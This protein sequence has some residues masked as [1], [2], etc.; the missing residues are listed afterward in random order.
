MPDVLW[1]AKIALGILGYLLLP[2]VL[3]AN[4]LDSSRSKNIGLSLTYGFLLQLLNIF[5]AWIFF[6]FLGS[7][8]FFF[9]ITFFTFVLIVIFLLVLSTRFTKISF[10]FNVESLKRMDFCLLFA[11]GL[12]LV[13]AYHFQQFAVE[14]HSD[15]ASYVDLARNVVENGVFKSSMIAPTYDWSNVVYSTGGHPHMFGY[16]A[17]ALFFLFGN[18][19][20][21]SAKI[22]LIF[23]GLLIINLTYLLTKEL[24]DINTARLASVMTSVSAIFLTH[25]G[26][27]GGPEIISA[28]FV[29]M[30]MYLI[31]AYNGSNKNAI[32]LVA[33]LSSFIAWYAVEF[34]FFV[35][36]ALFSL[37]VVF[38]ARQREED[39][40]INLFFTISLLV[41]F[42]IDVRMSSYFSFEKIGIPIPFISVIM[43]PLVYFLSIRKNSKTSQLSIVMISALIVLEF[44][45]LSFILSTPESKIFHANLLRVGIARANVERDLG[46]ISRMF[47]I[48]NIIHYWNMY[49]NG[50][51]KYLGQV[52]ILLAI[53][54]LGRLEKLKETI[55]LMLFPLFH[56]LLWIFF[57]T[58]DGF[59]PRFIVLCSIFYGILVASS[60]KTI[61]KNATNLMRNNKIVQLF[62]ARKKLR[63]D[64]KKLAGLSIAIMLIASYV[65]LAFETYNEGKKVMEFW[66][67]RQ[68]Y[69]W[70]DAIVWIKNNTYQTDAIASIY[71]DYFGW[72]TN[73]P[74][75]F[76]WLVS[77]KNESTLINLIRTLKV[78]YLVVDETFSRHFLDLKGLYDSPGPFLGS[79]IVFRSQ[80]EVGKKVVIYNVTN[81]AYGNLVTYEFEADWETLKHWAPLTFYSTGNISV[82]QDAVRFDLRV[83]GTQ[84]PSAAATFTFSSLANISQY[85]YMEFWIKVPKCQY[86][87]LVIYSHSE[88][89]SQNYFS[90]VVQNITVD[91][92][93]KNVIDLNS[94]KSIYGNPDLQNVD[95]LGFIVGGFQAGDNVTFWIRDL[96]FSMQEYVP[97]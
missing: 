2:G 15:G 89:P 70:D 26:L 92:W 69:G 54:S 35:F 51:F 61:A 8:N 59:Q 4:L 91:E 42:A 80:N 73:R 39:V 20:L 11:L 84:W 67:L 7:I 68:K 14:P 76:L 44:L 87:T 86:I 49:K 55:T 53:I 31:T 25:I 64:L 21:L 72:Y 94:Y 13:L 43:I 48:N 47:D 46:M 63:L 71:G 41:S 88:K 10:A 83:K 37:I 17:I 23:S 29:L 16:F 58:I 18:V 45:R 27:V 1:L 97:K 24:F 57:V 52:T 32:W 56:M 66:N 95:K 77:N 65:G 38:L 19:S 50:I 22:M 28:L 12:S 90:Y 85:S 82:S 79:K 9:I 33:A 6:M 75:V 96:M 3:F 36:L 62:G 34:N 60:I 74:T 78:K 81:I 30:T 93:V 40:K 5:G